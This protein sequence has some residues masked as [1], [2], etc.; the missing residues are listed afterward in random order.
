M[1]KS[2]SPSAGLWQE[3]VDSLSD[4]VVVFD[5]ALA[6]IAINPAAE[7]LFGVSHL[8]EA[9]VGALLRPNEWLPRRGETRLSSGPNLPDAA[10]KLTLGSRPAPGSPG[11]P[12]PSAPRAARPAPQGL[13]P[14]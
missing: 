13:G 9:A 1:R 5:T 11:A 12:P 10:A 7:T 8:N 14:N 6:P 4:A 3:I 2:P